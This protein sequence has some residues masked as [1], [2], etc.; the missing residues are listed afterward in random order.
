[1]KSFFSSAVSLSQGVSIS[2]GHGA[3]LVSF[4]ITPSRFWFSK[5]VSRSFS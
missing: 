3:S 2:A 4:G 5:I 1:M